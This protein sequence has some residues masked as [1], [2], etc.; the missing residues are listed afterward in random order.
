MAI[1][2]TRIVYKAFLLRSRER[3]LRSEELLQNSLCYERR[4]GKTT[5]RTGLS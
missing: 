3:E 4:V 1:L 2:G 5:N